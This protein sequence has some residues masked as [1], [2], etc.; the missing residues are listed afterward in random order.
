MI[1]GIIKFNLLHALNIFQIV[2][3]I[4]RLR[5]GDIRDHD[6]GTAISCE[7]LLHQ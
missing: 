2:N 4:F 1:L 3:Q 5:I 7:L 6:F